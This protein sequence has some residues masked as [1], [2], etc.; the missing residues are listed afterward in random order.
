V[1]TFC[2]RRACSDEGGFAGSAAASFPTLPPAILLKL[3]EALRRIAR[4]ERELAGLQT[5]FERYEGVDETAQMR[6]ADE[7]AALISLVQQLS[8]CR[9]TLSS[10]TDCTL[11]QAPP[12]AL[13]AYARGGRGGTGGGGGGGGDGS[14]RGSAASGS[15]SRV[16]FK[17]PSVLKKLRKKTGMSSRSER[18]GSGADAVARVAAVIGAT[19]VPSLGSNASYAADVSDPALAAAVQSVAE[20]LY[21][22]TAQWDYER[23]QD[24][25]LGVTAGDIVE[26]LEET[27][28]TWLFCRCGARVGSLPAAY[29]QRVDL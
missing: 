24:G 17:V 16:T 21:L 11:P 5:I 1:L 19:S 3:D 25:E 26:V 2:C 23:L 10:G 9:D 20:V 15:G 29:V 28:D 6:T 27:D 7:I 8:A 22:A 13:A 14:R 12:P 4:H 18:G